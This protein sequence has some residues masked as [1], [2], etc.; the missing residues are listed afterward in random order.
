MIYNFDTN[1]QNQAVAA[2]LVYAIYRSR[3]KKRFKVSL[4][5]WGQILG[6]VKSSAKRAKTLPAFI[7]KLQAKMSCPSL[8][9]QWLEVGIQGKALLRS[10]DSLIEMPRQGR[11]FL[12][13]VLDKADDK[14]VL[15][16]L[17]Y[18]TQVVVL[19]VRDRLEQEK[20][21]EKTFNIDEEQA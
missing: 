8:N 10:G 4:E 11:S 15:D 14:A 20:P 13:D 1:N 17:R 21:I 12:T 18:E 9:P 3:D 5:M 2:L 19:L 7:D 16:I 6:F